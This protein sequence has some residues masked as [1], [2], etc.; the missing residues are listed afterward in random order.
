MWTFSP[1]VHNFD[2]QSSTASSSQKTIID[3]LK[4]RGS[5]KKN[6]KKKKKKRSGGSRYSCISLKF[7]TDIWELS[8]KTLKP[9]VERT[10]REPPIPFQSG[11]SSDRCPRGR[12]APCT[13]DR[14]S[15]LPRRG[16]QTSRGGKWRTRSTCNKTASLAWPIIDSEPLIHH[17]LIGCLL[18]QQQ[19]SRV[20]SHLRDSM[21][22][23]GWCLQFESGEKMEFTLNFWLSRTWRSE[24]KQTS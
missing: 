15:S 1:L 4:K 21:S 3:A 24:Q 9:N 10:C 6:W 2:I 23:D 8:Q 19:E 12:R 16:R 11:F 17:C 18:K 14:G 20:S 7:K 5:E 22:R 13:A